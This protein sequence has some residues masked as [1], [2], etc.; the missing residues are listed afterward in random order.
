VAAFEEL[1]SC[2]PLASH[3]L[4]SVEVY[5]AV[6]M[7][8]LG[9]DLVSLYCQVVVSMAGLVKEPAAIWLPN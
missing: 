9:L 5:A 7:A 4:C 8:V 1:D 6:G 2:L 3:F